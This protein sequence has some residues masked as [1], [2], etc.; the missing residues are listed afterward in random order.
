MTPPLDA[1]APARPENFRYSPMFPLGA[2]T[3]PWRKLPIEG[4]PC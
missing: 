1:A 3:T 2:D 4:R